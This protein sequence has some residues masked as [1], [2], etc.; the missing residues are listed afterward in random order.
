[1]SKDLKKMPGYQYNLDCPN[2]TMTLFVITLLNR[3]KVNPK[4]DYKVIKSWYIDHG[5]IYECP[6]VKDVEGVMLGKRI[7]SLENVREQLETRYGSTRNTKAQKKAVT[8]TGVEGKIVER[9]WGRMAERISKS[10]RDK[11]PK[12]DDQAEDDETT[13]EVNI[14]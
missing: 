14:E 1:M 12:E 2:N 10:N 11:E 7:R 6:R 9:V 13:K 8:L 5:V 4:R 3:G